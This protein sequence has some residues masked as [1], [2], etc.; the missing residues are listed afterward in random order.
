[1]E[2][3]ESPDFTVSQHEPPTPIFFNMISSGQKFVKDDCSKLKPTNAV[4]QSQFWLW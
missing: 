1:L 3:Q 4:N 2:Q